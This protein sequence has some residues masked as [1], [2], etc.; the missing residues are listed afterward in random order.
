MRRT[1]VLLA[2][3]LLA[4]AAG[5]TADGSPAPGYTG[6]TPAVAGTTPGA[7]AASVDP[8]VAAAGDKALSGNTKAI[9]DQA[10]RA[11]T[12]FGETFIADL[13]LQIDAAKQGAAAKAQAQAKINRDVSSYSSALAGM[14]ALTDDATLKSTLTEMSKLVRALKGDFTK[15]NPE[16]ISAITA[17]LDQAC[18]TG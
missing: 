14:A 17:R 5:C 11:G 2:I 3:P 7:G 18:H 6:R 13:K 8:S 10:A 15:I 4:V 1:A 16:E 12:S 9:C